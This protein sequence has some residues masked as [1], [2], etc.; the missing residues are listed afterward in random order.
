MRRSSLKLPLGGSI[1]SSSLLLTRKLIW[2]FK[3]KVHCQK[4][5]IYFIISLATN[6]FSL[7]RYATQKKTDKKIQQDCWFSQFKSFF[8]SKDKKFYSCWFVLVDLLLEIL[9]HGNKH[10]VYILI[11]RAIS[12]VWVSSFRSTMRVAK[13][14]VWNIFTGRC[15]IIL[16]EQQHL[17]IYQTCKS[18]LKH[19]RTV[20]LL[21]LLLLLTLTIV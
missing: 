3:H 6:T 8:N 10:Y 4:Y 14:L 7:T 12:S 2:R 15:W 1:V 19:I 20:L 17:S 16:C 5:F 11:C 18:T 13:M 9:P 21:L